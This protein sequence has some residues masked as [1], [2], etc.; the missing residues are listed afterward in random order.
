MAE[1]AYWKGH[2]RLSLVSFPVRLYASVT[3]TEKVQ[4]HKYDKES[5]SRIRYANVNAE[6]E[7][8]EAD[9][10][11]R[12]YEYEKGSF[13]EI[14]NKDLD[15]LKVESKHT[16]DLIQFTDMSSI[17]AVYYDH[18]YFVAPESGVGVEAFVTIRDAL[19]ATGKV[20]LGQVVMNN[21][22]RIVA[23]KPCGK[24]LILETLRYDYEVRERD[25]YFDE[26]PQNVDVPKDQIDLAKMLIDSKT[27]EFD[28][29]KFKDRYQE[30]LL[31]IINAKLDHRKPDLDEP[32][33]KPS[34]VVNI[35]EALKRSLE[36][37]KASGDKK[38]E[39]DKPAPKAKVKDEKPKK[40][41]S[42]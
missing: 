18:P 21:K 5:G 16:I 33:A 13:V 30:G 32:K 28:P 2:I 3:S 10:I 23:I 12:G 29:K 14:E 11:V 24:G 41:K 38:T 25:Q 8:V 17:D 42:A 19:K 40:K 36:Q 22:E 1:R 15:A 27:A 31:E 35:M 26:I 4:L 34:K 20:A 9:D 6:G 39:A 37:S 7:K